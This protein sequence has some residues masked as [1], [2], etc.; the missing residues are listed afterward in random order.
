MRRIQNLD[1][2]TKTQKSRKTDVVDKIITKKN[3]PDFSSSDLKDHKRWLRNDL[4]NYRIDVDNLKE[5]QSHPN[6]KKLQDKYKDTINAMVGVSGKSP[7]KE[8]VKEFLSALRNFPEVHD[9]DQSVSNA[10]YFK[11]SMDKGKWP[12]TYNGFGYSDSSKLSKMIKGWAIVDTLTADELI[13]IQNAIR[14]KYE[15]FII[16]YLS[17][18]R[19]EELIKSNI[20]ELRSKSDGI[21]HLLD[22]NIP[23]TLPEFFNLIKEE[24]TNGNGISWDEWQNLKV[25]EKF[26]KS[27]HSEVVSSSFST[28]YYYDLE[29][30]MLGKTFTYKDVQ[31]SSDY[32]S[33]GWD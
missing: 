18:K 19:I 5:L 32:Y 25:K 13:I 4:D 15:K 10:A 33:G 6:F 24:L 9:L 22:I 3:F 2:F 1:E 26:S 30:T 31:V 17:D 8:F 27:D 21:N 23:R 12:V 16:Y 11:R 29:I 14:P 20:R 7:N 28:Y